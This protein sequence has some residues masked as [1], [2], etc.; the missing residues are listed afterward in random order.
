MG[1]LSACCSPTPF[2]APLPQRGA[3]E[4]ALRT[5]YLLDAVDVHGHI[6][7]KLWW[8]VAGT[9]GGSRQQHTEAGGSSERW[10]WQPL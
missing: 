10:G 7:G 2:C 5:L 6:T 8:A 9:G 3:L 1:L 4:D